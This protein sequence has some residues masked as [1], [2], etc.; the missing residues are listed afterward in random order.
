M[1]CCSRWREDTRT[2]AKERTETGVRDKS[3]S[4]HFGDEPRWYCAQPSENPHDQAKPIPLER[5]LTQQWIRARPNAVSAI[6]D[7]IVEAIATTGLYVGESVINAALV[8]ALRGR[9]RAVHAQHGLRPAQIGRSTKLTSVTQWRGDS[10]AWFDQDALD[11]VEARTMELI[12]SLRAALNEALY[13]GAVDTECHFARYP[14][15]AFYK[16]H[17]DR[18]GDHDLRVVSLIFYLN[19]N[20]KE[21]HGG[22]LLIYDQAGNL[23]ERVLPQCGTMVAFLSEQFPHEVLPA[24]RPRLSLSG[25]MRR[26]P[27]AGQ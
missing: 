6:N 23:I 21:D 19:S 15:G 14:R 4:T 27:L 24:T 8:S 12:N 3:N 2:K 11:P 17:F 10:I 5:G 20:W 16:T 7:R 22:E 1:R 13:I 26:R 9:L 25:W 18:F